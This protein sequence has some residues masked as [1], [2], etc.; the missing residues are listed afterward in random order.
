[1]VSAGFR[2][3]PYT[4]QTPQWIIWVSS[5]VTFGIARQLSI[6][7]QSINSKP[8][9]SNVQNIKQ[10]QQTADSTAAA[11]AGAVASS[12]HCFIAYDK[13]LSWLQMLQCILVTVASKLCYYHLYCCWKLFV[14]RF[15]SQSITRTHTLT[16]YLQPHS[17][18]RA[19]I[20]SHKDS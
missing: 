13:K 12:C 5:S 1:M 10:W 4:P 18:T 16:N 15:K 7:V 19:I 2:T 11:A 17:Q 9:Y 8:Q 20:K 14:F 3:M 6:S